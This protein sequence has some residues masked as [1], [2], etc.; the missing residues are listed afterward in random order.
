M[1]AADSAPEL[2]VARSRELLNA[3]H[4]INASDSGM[5]NL[6]RIPRR[7][8]TSSV[9]HIPKISNPV[10]LDR[11]S[12]T[13]ILR[14]PL[15]HLS[16][17]A[18]C[19]CD[20]LVLL[21]LLRSHSADKDREVVEVKKDWGE[22]VVTKVGLTGEEMQG[23][24]AVDSH[25]IVLEA[26]AKAGGD[27]CQISSLAVEET[28]TGYVGK[29]MQQKLRANGT[30]YVTF[31]IFGT[32]KRKLE[33]ED[34]VVCLSQRRDTVVLPCRH[35]CLCSGC[36]EVFRKQTSCKCPMC[37]SSKTYADVESLIEVPKDTV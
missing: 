27:V 33:S 7:Y 12:F 8:P 6:P 21:S 15:Y 28:E 35:M 29:L 10:S 34:C 9:R 2:D 3:L 24:A 22:E 37:R 16:F 26:R 14:P 31:E 11:D 30:E 19:A 4:R 36:A 5:A 13:F 25:T 1:G 17:T 32:G 23:C 18:I 20:G